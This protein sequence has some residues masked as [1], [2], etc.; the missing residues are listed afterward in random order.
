[1]EKIMIGDKEY[2]LVFNMYTMELIEE[3]YDDARAVINRLVESPKQE[4]KLCRELFVMMANTAREL[5]GEP[6]DVTD[7]ALKG[8]NFEDYSK[9][10]LR[11]KLIIEVAHGMKS[12]T[13]GGNVADDTVHDAFLEEDEKNG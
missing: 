5:K 4:L 1:M 7:E 10:M 13:T 3:K 11:A 12:E 2:D 8:M 9:L 6:E